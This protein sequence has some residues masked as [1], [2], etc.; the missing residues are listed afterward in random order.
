MV[1]AGLFSE[2][3]IE[4][5]GFASQMKTVTSRGTTRAVGRT[6]DRKHRSVRTGIGGA[7]AI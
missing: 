6:S 1:T 5:K 2:D 4:R 3:D 7:E